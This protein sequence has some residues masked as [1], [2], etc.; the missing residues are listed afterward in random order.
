MAID[1]TG[2]NNENEFYTQH[3]LSAIFENDIKDL[4]AKW[5]LEKEETRPPY[6]Q[7]KSL[8]KD[9]F[10]FLSTF[11]KEKTILERIELQHGWFDALLPALG[12]TIQPQ[13]KEIEN[14]ISIP[15]LFEKNKANG[16]PELWVLESVNIFEEDLDPLSLNFHKEQY[17]GIDFP[18][19]LED[20]PLDI[21]I[22]KH[23]FG[24]DEPPRW[25][26]AVNHS[27]MMLIDRSKWN[28]KRMLRFDLPEIIGRKEDT[29]L[30]AMAVL[31]H[32]DS[33]IPPEGI[34][35]LDTLDENS[36]K[37]AFAVSNDLKYALREAIELI[38]N[39]AVYYLQEIRKKG[40][41][42]G[43]EKLDA[44]AAKALS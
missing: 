13:L 41:F 12:Y 16:A 5:N 35:L 10:V 9:Y 22:T 28:E 32:K 33:V 38:G 8:S 19:I 7:I 43:D 40:V 15:I 30:K 14:D 42:S 36:H 34:P 31:L 37:H 23:I 2:I 1:L 18:K 29:T 4:L 26:I 6:A 27:Q 44:D 3:Y 24:M 11:N 25:I 21:V 39:E 17:G 20:T